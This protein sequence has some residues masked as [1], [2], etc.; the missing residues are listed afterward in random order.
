MIR[1][2]ESILKFAGGVLACG[3]LLLL[4]ACGPSFSTQS[5]AQPTVTINPNFQ[6][7][8]PAPKAP[9]YRCG[10]WSSNNAPGTGSV[11]TIYARLIKGNSAEPEAG[12]TAIA[13]AHFQFGDAQLDQQP[14]SDAGGYVS[15]S[16]PLQGRQPAQTPATV[17]VTFTGTIGTVHC[18]SAFFTP[19]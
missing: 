3:A 14:V 15:F 7:G 10:A 11:I 17:D 5:A 18:S 16:L 2:L 12:A 1:I 6:A 19:R 8:S 13:V 9:T 4:T